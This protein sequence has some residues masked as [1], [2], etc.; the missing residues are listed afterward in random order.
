M[1]EGKLAD[2]FTG[3]KWDVTVQT[4]AEERQS[5]E[6]AIKDA[7]KRKTAEQDAEDDNALMAALD[8][9]DPEHRGYGWNLLQGEARLSDARMQRAVTRL[10]AEVI[11]ELTV[12]AKIGSGAKRQVKGLRRK[13][14]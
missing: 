14:E 9:L 8:R 12:S 11:E 10:K 5:A 2:D 3:R 4:F 1:S 6:Q 7:R 13:P